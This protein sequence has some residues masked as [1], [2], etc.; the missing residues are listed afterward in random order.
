MEQ[1]FVESI[2]TH[3]EEVPIWKLCFVVPKGGNDTPGKF[4][5]R[6]FGPFRVQY[7]LPNNLIL[8]VSINYF[9]PNPILV[10]INKLKRYKYV[11]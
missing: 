3:K 2:E 4:K 6:W 7:C 1:I 10:N 8:L 9:E 11:D 5:K